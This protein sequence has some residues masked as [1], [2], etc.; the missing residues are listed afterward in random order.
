MGLRNNS[1]VKN[2][3]RLLIF[4]TKPYIDGI[5]A[6][7]T[8]KSIKTSTKKKPYLGAG[9]FDDGV[10][11]SPPRSGRDVHAFSGEFALA[12]WVAGASGDAGAHM[13]IDTFGSPW[14]FFTCQHKQRSH[15]QIFL[16]YAQPAKVRTGA[17]TFQNRR[18]GVIPGIG[19]DVFVVIF[20][21]HIV[22]PVLAF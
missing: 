9:P 11:P 12:D 17:L 8:R 14:T 3:S 2:N 18:A 1:P 10:C 4:I 21:Q 5:Q 20:T 13:T 7:K 15:Q 6:K 16:F 19:P 22:V